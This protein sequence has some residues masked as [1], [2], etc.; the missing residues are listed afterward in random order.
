[1][2]EG[3]SPEEA[4][5]IKQIIEIGESQ[6]QIKQSFWN[7]V[8]TP[9]V[10]KL[11]EESNILWKDYW[12]IDKKLREKIIIHNSNLSIYDSDYINFSIGTCGSVNP[13]IQDDFQ[14]LISI[15]QGKWKR[16]KSAND[17]YTKALHKNIANLSL[18]VTPENSI[19]MNSYGSTRWVFTEFYCSCKPFLILDICGC[20]VIVI[21]DIFPGKYCQT[22]YSITMS[23][24]KNRSDYEIENKKQNFLD[25]FRK[26]FD[27]YRKNLYSS[28]F[29]KK[30]VPQPFENLYT[31][32][33]QTDSEEYGR[34]RRYLIIGCMTYEKR[35]NLRSDFTTIKS[36]DIFTN[37][38]IA[39][40]V[41]RLCTH[42]QS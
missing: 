8:N 34:T 4:E 24:L 29:Y 1:M 28:P 36:S 11:K 10:L 31:L 27:P 20:E 15:S 42:L 6:K 35:M 12:S 22:E 17:I 18:T 32:Y 13:N 26:E 21:Q 41:P 7:E 33:A 25:N 9:E 14:E 16:Y 39:E 38:R 5:R 23:D 40:S 30:P 2:N 19:S 3:Y 37:C